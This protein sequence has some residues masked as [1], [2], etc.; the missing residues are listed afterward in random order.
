MSEMDEML[1]NPWSYCSISLVADDCCY[2]N[3]R[4]ESQHQ[5][6]SKTGRP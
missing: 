1:P 2:D 3:R 5:W 6:H 4:R